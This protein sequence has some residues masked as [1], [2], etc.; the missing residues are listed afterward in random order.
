MEEEQCGAYKNSY[1]QINL[2]FP[3]NNFIYIF[4]TLISLKNHQD[5][6][7]QQGETTNNVL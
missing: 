4:T 5:G 2:I 3:R 6:P 1:F 7:N